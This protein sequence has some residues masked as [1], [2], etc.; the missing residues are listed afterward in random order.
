MKNFFLS[1]VPPKGFQKLLIDSIKLNC[2][3]NNSSIDQFLIFK[4]KKISFDSLIFI[5]KQ[6]ISLNIFKKNEI[7]KINYKNYN[8]TRYAI[9]E[10]FKNYNSYNNIIFYCYFSIITYFKCARIVDAALAYSR[11]R[12]VSAYIDHGMYTNG[13]IVEI[14]TKRNIPIYSI[15][16]PHG[17]F[18]FYNKNFIKRSYED[19]VQLKKKIFLNKSKKKKVT[20]KIQ[21]IIREPQTI[22]WLKNIN[23]RKNF[24]KYKDVT[25]V[26][27]THSFTDAQ[28]M[29]G[30]DGFQNVYE[31]LK[32]TLDELIKNNNKILIKAHP[33]FFHNN[34]PSR[35]IEYDK[36]LLL[37]LISYYKNKN[38]V[39]LLD[40]IKNFNL[41]NTL[42]KRVI[43]ISHHGSAILEGSYLGFKCISSKATL[44]STNFR[45][46]NNW[47]N[48]IQ[49]KK[50]LNKKWNKLYFSNKKDFFSIIYQLYELKYGI[51]GNNYW[52]KIISRNLKISSEKLFE[53]FNHILVNTKK[54]NKNYNKIK[55]S[56]SKNIEKIKI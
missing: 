55:I 21:K 22:P 31:W 30:F 43:L 4:T 52:V 56:I 26:I 3:K 9:P 46:T 11:K 42:S 20:R 6:I 18:C 13:L 47:S 23:F 12:I 27:Y 7:V 5:L 2:K 40:P 49:Y 36:K 54:Y 8:L 17:I 29:Y 53:N 38:I 50:L 10:I 14:F 35:L 19:I 41:L 24:K 33:S 37:K 44:W 25:H 32:F 39:F 51:Y 45:L 28:M 1:T 16:Y 48:K 15:G 34:F